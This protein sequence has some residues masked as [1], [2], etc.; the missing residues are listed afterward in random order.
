MKLCLRTGIVLTAMLV[1]VACSAGDLY[2]IS[3]GE[4]G[5]SS[6][7]YT[8]TE[9]KRT[10]RISFLHIPGFHKRSAEAA[11]WMLCV[12]NDIAQ[13]RGFDAWSVVY[14]DPPSE[15]LILG[16]PLFPDEKIASTLGP[17]FGTKNA[18]PVVSVQSMR[19][20]CEN[21]KNSP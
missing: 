18:L 17:E 11:R 8:V 6:F 4:M 10:D 20:L 12:Y 9:T 13:K 7:D 3:A 5:F 21:M 19:L 14:P 16:F 1:A 2:R 15:D